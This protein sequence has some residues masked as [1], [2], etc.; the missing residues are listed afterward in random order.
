MDTHGGL[1]MSDDQVISLIWGNI[2]LEEKFAA[3]PYSFTLEEIK[4]LK[5]S[6]KY[7]IH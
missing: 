5:D 7:R 1:M 3:D 2:E 6:D 4:M